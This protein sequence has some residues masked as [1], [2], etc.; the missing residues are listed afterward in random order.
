MKKIELLNIPLSQMTSLNDH[1]KMA[2]P[3]IYSEQGQAEALS[4]ISQQI[5]TIRPVY[6]EPL[7]QIIKLNLPNPAVDYVEAGYDSCQSHRKLAKVVGEVFLVGGLTQEAQLLGLPFDIGQV[8]AMVGSTLVIPPEYNGVVCRISQELGGSQDF[9]FPGVTATT[10]KFLSPEDLAYSSLKGHPEVSVRNLTGVGGIRKDNEWNMATDLPTFVNLKVQE[11]KRYYPGMGIFYWLSKLPPGE[12]PAMDAL[13]GKSIYTKMVALAEAAK[14]TPKTEVEGL[15]VLCSAYLP[16]WKE[17]K[18]WLPFS[19]GDGILDFSTAY[20]SPS[21]EFHFLSTLFTDLL[22]GKRPGAQTFSQIDNLVTKLNHL[23]SFNSTIHL[24]WTSEL[25]GLSND[26][27]GKIT[28]LKGDHCLRYGIG[29]K[30]KS[31]EIR[32]YHYGQNRNFPFEY[33]GKTACALVYYPH[34]DVFGGACQWEGLSIT[35]PMWSGLTKDGLV[36]TMLKIID[37]Y[38]K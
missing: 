37:N 1:L 30:G 6:Q 4:W 28:N 2:K 27:M 36:K 5:A 20:H 7:K 10:E 3:F 35:D 11:D 9:L 26:L 38:D 22:L 21:Y 33:Q 31:L 32:E 17:M 12:I 16:P 14:N 34:S 15:T 23:W 18:K 13:R 24:P 8:Q 25:A 29:S 19:S